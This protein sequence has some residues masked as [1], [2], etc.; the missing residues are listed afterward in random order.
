MFILT[1][2][3]GTPFEVT[4]V[5]EEDIVQICMTLGHIHP[6]GVLQYL[7]TEPVALFHT[8]EEMQRESCGAITVRELCNEPIAI[9]IVAPTEPHIRAYITVRG[10]PFKP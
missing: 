3:D 6:M 9:K 8:V 4:S 10:L 7:A 1:H 5:T 2:K